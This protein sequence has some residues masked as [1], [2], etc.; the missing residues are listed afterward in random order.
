MNSLESMWIAP[1]GAYHDLYMLPNIIH[2]LTR[3][4]PCFE[5]LYLFYSSSP[6]SAVFGL[7]YFS[8]RICGPSCS[9]G[10][11]TD[12]LNVPPTSSKF[13]GFLYPIG[14]TELWDKNS[15]TSGS[16]PASSDCVPCG[17]KVKGN[18]VV[19]LSWHST[20]TYVRLIEQ[21]GARS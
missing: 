6:F 12:M 21:G 1:A 2:Q 3:S 18:N 20:A 5:S 11:D 10:G 8:P 7:I 16:T 9:P 15:V 19:R 4:I 14:E 17:V 13:V